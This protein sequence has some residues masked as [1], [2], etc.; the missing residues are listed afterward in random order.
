MTGIGVGGG[1]VP[2]PVPH[3]GESVASDPRVVIWH[4]AS[5]RTFALLKRSCFSGRTT[6][7]PWMGAYHQIPALR[8]LFNSCGVTGGA[9][10]SAFGALLE[11]SGPEGVVFEQAASTAAP[12]IPIKLR[13]LFT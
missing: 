4:S 8:M 2:A 5:G 12:V 6:D 10:G 13:R 7:E 1:G 3:P 11:T 9:M